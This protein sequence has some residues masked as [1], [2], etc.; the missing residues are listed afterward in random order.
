MPEASSTAEAHGPS[1][2]EPMMIHSSES[3]GRVAMTLCEVKSIHRR[4][5]DDAT[6]DRAG[7]EELLQ[8]GR[9]RMR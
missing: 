5:D 2:C 3:P 1:W 7:G 4:V 9:R 8:R 6:A